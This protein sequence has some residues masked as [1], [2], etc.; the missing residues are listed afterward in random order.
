LFGFVLLLVSASQCTA[1]D[2]AEPLTDENFYDKIKEGTWI[3]DF[4]APWCG[5]CKR[6]APEMDKLVGMVEGTAHVATVDATANKMTADRHG[7]HGYPS[8]K[9]FT[10]GGKRVTDYKGPRDAEHLAAF[11]RKMLG[12]LVTVVESE[13][14]QSKWAKAH[15]TS[16]VLFGG[17]SEKSKDAFREMAKSRQ[18]DVYFA[19]SEVSFC[20]TEYANFLKKLGAEFEC[21]NVAA[22]ALNDGKAREVLSDA[23]FEANL[24]KFIEDNH[25]PM[26]SEL[27]TTTFWDFVNSGRRV[28]LAFLDPYADAR[29][30]EYKQWLCNTGYKNK[31]YRFAWMDAVKHEQFL[32]SMSVTKDDVPVLA[33]LDTPSKI[34][35]VHRNRTWTKDEFLRQVEA[36]NVAAEGEGTGWWSYL[37][38]HM[39]GIIVVLF[40]AV[41]GFFM[42]LG[43]PSDEPAPAKPAIAKKDD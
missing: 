6:L 41:I 24:A 16:F 20:D 12:P 33:V 37:K 17:A 1:A 5:H 31:N 26:C 30:T 23:D 3:V 7:V 14:E 19:Q 32:G 15:T 9:L 10:E 35:Y 2:K 36:G 39:L 4:F 27:Q 25:M 40:V 34:H 43:D 11:I 18:A 22:L 38:S 29:T 21:S 42:W 13:A 8:L 28:V